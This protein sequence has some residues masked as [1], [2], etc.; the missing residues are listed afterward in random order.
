M[1][2][3]MSRV[4]AP[5]LTPLLSERDEMI[6]DVVIEIPAGSKNKYEIDH[7][8]GEIRLDRMLMTSTR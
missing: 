8:T 3:E 5:S 7:K 2:S 4:R 1:W 6:F